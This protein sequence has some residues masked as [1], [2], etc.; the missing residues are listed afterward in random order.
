MWQVA[1]GMDQARVLRQPMGPSTTKL[2]AR[3]I[4]QAS[5]SP[6][7]RQDEG[8]SACRSDQRQSCDQSCRTQ[9]KPGTPCASESAVKQSQILTGENHPRETPKVRLQA[10]VQYM[11]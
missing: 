9:K 7:F 6:V 5:L 8:R 4:T 1:L 3:R 10:S 11:K 2:A